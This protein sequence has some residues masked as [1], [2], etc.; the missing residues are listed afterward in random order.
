[1]VFLFAGRV[2]D[3]LKFMSDIV[4]NRFKEDTPMGGL[5]GGRGGQRLE[6]CFCQQVGRERARVLTSLVERFVSLTSLP[7]RR[8][9]A[10]APG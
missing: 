3:Y 9:R 5:S 10:P 6:V 4:C 1:M 7:Q 2:L 8:I